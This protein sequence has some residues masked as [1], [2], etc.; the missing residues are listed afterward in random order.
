MVKVLPASLV[1]NYI[2]LYVTGVVEC[3]GPHN[4]TKIVER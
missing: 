3:I 2:G 4:Y 1:Y